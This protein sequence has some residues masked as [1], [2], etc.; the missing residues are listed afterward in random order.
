MIRLPTHRSPEHPGVLLRE[1]YLP[2]LGLTQQELAERL[3]VSFRR[4]NEI[5]N[6]KRPVTLDT[7]LR[8]GR[9]FGQSPAF[10]MNL[11]LAYD[12]WHAEHGGGPADLDEI[13]PLQ[14]AAG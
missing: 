13:Q 10:W 2:E 5:L 7:A 4:V 12:L 6:G 9:L 14:S 3:H 8:L 1:D 11:Q